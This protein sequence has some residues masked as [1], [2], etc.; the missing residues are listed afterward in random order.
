MRGGGRGHMTTQPVVQQQAHRD[1]AVKLLIA[2]VVG[3][4]VSLALG[5]YSNVHDPTGEQPYTLFFTG[6]IQLKVWFATAA[7]GSRAC[8]CCSARGSSTRSTCRATHRRGW[9]TRTG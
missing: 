5:V 1:P 9:A 2:L 7:V 4:A 3:G 6:T 8:R